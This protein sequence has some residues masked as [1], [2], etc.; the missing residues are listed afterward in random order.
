MKPIRIILADDHHLVR[1][2]LRV[3]L[4]TQS[5]FEVVGETGDGLETMKLT[6]QIQPD[7]LVLDVMIPGLNG[8]AAAKQI[9]RRWPRTRIVMLSMHA[10]VAYV[11]EAFRNGATGYVLKDCTAA[12]LVQAVRE[13]AA[14]GRFLSPPLSESALE[15]YE[16]RFNGGQ[17]DSYATL[18]GREREVF[19]LVAEGLTNARIGRRLSISPRTVEVHR[20]RVMDKLGLRTSAEV[21]RFAIRRGILSANGEPAHK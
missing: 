3:L 20:A 1:A 17:K 9:H 4:S 6:E 19:Q 5:D 21:V 16:H 13:V 12:D 8:L 18:T 14:G 11:A 15:D 10:D 2:G 7:I